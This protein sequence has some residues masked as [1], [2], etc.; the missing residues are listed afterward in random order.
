MTTGEDAPIS[1]VSG[2][3]AGR[4]ATE[5]HV[6][7]K[8]RTEEQWPGMVTR[9]GTETLAIVTVSR[10]D[11]LR[12]EPRDMSRLA[13]RAVV[14]GDCEQTCRRP[15]QLKSPCAD[16]NMQSVLTAYGL[17]GDRVLS[18][19][20]LMGAIRTD[21]TLQLGKD[22]FCVGYADR[23]PFY[24]QQGLVQYQPGK[25]HESQGFNAFFARANELSALTCLGT[26][27]TTQIAV[28]LHDGQQ[29]IIGILTAT[30]K[31]FVRSQE[32]PVANRRPLQSYVSLA[33]WRAAQHYNIDPKEIY[34]HLMQEPREAARR[35]KDQVAMTERFPGW[36]EEGLIYNQK[37]PYWHTIQ[38]KF[39]QQNWRVRLGVAAL[40]DIAQAAYDLGPSADVHLSLP[41]PG[42]SASK[43]NKF[44]AG[45]P[46][47]DRGT[48]D[49]YIVVHAGS[50]LPSTHGGG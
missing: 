30:V 44:S 42:R 50:V 35:F 29:S 16:R 24:I 26:L 19:Q 43:Q 37:E 20:P 31:N 22:A 34:V 11:G 21:K 6:L 1:E 14:T 47:C 4:D 23:L 12:I 41:P 15:E 33:L 7:A 10:P 40:S 32:F 49:L 38:E 45:D 28:E 48:K 27:S 25:W 17:P 36:F 46:E 3:V 13:C 9:V 18:L 8:I 5:R 2:D 39:P